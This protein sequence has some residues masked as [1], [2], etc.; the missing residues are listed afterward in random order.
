MLFRKETV[1][2]SIC[3]PTWLAFDTL[4]D[5]IY[6]KSE[7]APTSNTWLFVVRCFKWFWTVL[8]SKRPETLLPGCTLFFVQN[9]SPSPVGQ[10]FRPRA[11]IWDPL[12]KL[13]D[14][15]WEHVGGFRSPFSKQIQE[16]RG[17][18][19]F[20]N[21]PP[22]PPASFQNLLF[23]YIRTISLYEVSADTHEATH[24]ISDE[25]DEKVNSSCKVWKHVLQILMHTYIYIYILTETFKNRLIG[26][27][28][29]GRSSLKQTWERHAIIF[30][31]GRTLYP[32]LRVGY[33]GTCTLL[34]RRLSSCIH[35]NYAACSIRFRLCKTRLVLLRRS[36]KS[37]VHRQAYAHRERLQCTREQKCLSIYI[38]Y[39]YIYMYIDLF[40]YMPTAT[41]S[42]ILSSTVAGSARL[43]HWIISPLPHSYPL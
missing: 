11:S 18:M 33:E 14:T 25:T 40:I 17:R 31:V 12:F 36:A 4:L 23:S 16:N 32:S 35:I 20:Q 5:T 19:C 10:L 30:R 3:V 9:G 15:F 8:A 28:I 26:Y 22:T 21:A 41:Y 6:E 43:R 34:I 2:V 37:C 38:L 29:C 39:I 42:C 24:T 27:I 13:S 7:P 1:F